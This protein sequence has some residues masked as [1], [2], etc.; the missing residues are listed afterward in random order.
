M[1][2]CTYETGRHLLPQDRSD[3]ICIECG[4]PV[5]KEIRYVGY[6]PQRPDHAE[7]IW[8]RVDRLARSRRPV[9]QP[10]VPAAESLPLNPQ[11][12]AI[13]AE[14]QRQAEAAFAEQATHG[15]DYW[16]DFARDDDDEPKRVPA[17]SGTVD[18]AKRRSGDDS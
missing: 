16:A 1:S 9:Y 8:L 11:D 18:I 15:P 3:P 2:R 17:D 6:A 12:V 14:A 13:L 7:T 4:A 5:P 10:Q